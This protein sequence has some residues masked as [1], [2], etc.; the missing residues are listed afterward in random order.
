MSSLSLRAGSR[1]RMYSRTCFAILSFSNF[2]AAS[3]ELH[4]KG[5]LCLRYERPLA[6]SWTRETEDIRKKRYQ[7]HLVQED[8]HVQSTNHAPSELVTLTRLKCAFAF[9]YVVAISANDSLVKT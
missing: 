5:P 1:K 8:P 7:I 2:A 6:L 3:S 9:G 4:R